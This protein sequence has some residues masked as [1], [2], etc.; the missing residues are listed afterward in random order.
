MS[1]SNKKI[2]ISNIYVKY[3]LFKRAKFHNDVMID[4]VGYR[5]YGHNEL[6]EPMLT[7]PIMY[8]H[9]KAHPNVLDVYSDKL[10]KDGVI[11]ETFIKEVCRNT[12]NRVFNV[13]LLSHLLFFCFRKSIST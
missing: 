11:T 8:K 4:I 3:Y 7:Q 1:D 12:F 6:D 5:R 10:L 9:I 2:F 13:C